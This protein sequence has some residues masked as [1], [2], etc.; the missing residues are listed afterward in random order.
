RKISGIE[1]RLNKLLNLDDSL[2]GGKTLK[3]PKVPYRVRIEKV[4]DEKGE[5]KV[6]IESEGGEESKE[7]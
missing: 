3:H 2:K 7:E 1:T 4:V 5:E 6:L